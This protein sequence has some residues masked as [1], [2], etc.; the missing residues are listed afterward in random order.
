MESHVWKKGKSGNHPSLGKTA[1]S[2]GHEPD[3]DNVV[4][5]ALVDTNDVINTETKTE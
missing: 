4:E 5:Y 3:D 1:R 2:V